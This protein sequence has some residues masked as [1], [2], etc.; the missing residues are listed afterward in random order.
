LQ[1]HNIGSMTEDVDVI[2]GKGGAMEA[3]LEMKEQKVTRFLGVTGHFRP[4]VLM[5]CL[6]RYSFDTILMALNAADPHHF[7]FQDDL[8]PMAVER[9]M[10]IIGM[11]IPARSRILSTWTP[12]P[13]EQ[14][15]G[16]YEG[17]TVPAK[18]PGT[19]NI[20]EAMYYTLSHPVSTVIIGCDSVAHVEENVRLAREFT[21][22]SDSQL[23][24]LV[25][26]VEP[27]HQQALFFR[28]APHA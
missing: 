26:R 2:F 15:K 16:T 11:K 18:T 24:D 22:L 6:R 14:Q 7:S 28:F 12:P 21:P 9:Q 8:L 3:L 13:L 1:L 19:I 23:A 27:I 20:H 5:E 25:K 10:G 4:D 17:G